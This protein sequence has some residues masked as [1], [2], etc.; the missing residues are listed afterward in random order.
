MY[1]I[2]FVLDDTSLLDELLASWSEAGISGATIIESSGLYRRM[3]KTIPMRY[4]YGSESEDEKGNLTLFVAVESEEKVHTCLHAAE[5]VVGDLND[6]NSGVFLAW[7]L[8]FSK[9]IAS[10]QLKGD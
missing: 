8:T 2:M 4:L 6:P 9:G 3:K 5:K 1:M 7:P 10:H